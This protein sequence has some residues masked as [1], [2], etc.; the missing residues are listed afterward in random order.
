M[1][2]ASFTENVSGP[3]MSKLDG[4]SKSSNHSRHVLRYLVLVKM[5]MIRRFQQRRDKF[6]NHHPWWSALRE[7]N[8]YIKTC[9]DQSISPSYVRIKHTIIQNY[10]DDVAAK[11]K[12]DEHR[13]QLLLSC[14][15]L[16]ASKRS[17]VTL[18]RRSKAISS[19]RSKTI[20]SRRSKPFHQGSNAFIQQ[21]QQQQQQRE[22]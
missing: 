16:I 11:I 1:K 8:V 6:R 17:K 2:L 13:V 10:G 7:T 9:T 21:Q 18:S 22:W 5:S 12:A 20:S 3:T 14:P 15:L 19:R 4:S